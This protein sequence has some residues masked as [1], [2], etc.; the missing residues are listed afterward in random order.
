[1]QKFLL[2]VGLKS[3]KRKDLSEQNKLQSFTS[4]I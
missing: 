3:K 4:N 1:M 2:R